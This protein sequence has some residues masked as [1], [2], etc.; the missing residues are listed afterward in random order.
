MV[1]QVDLLLTLEEFCGAEGDF[2]NERGATF[3]PMFCQ[4]LQILYD[5]DI[6][7]EE[8]C[9][10]WASEKENAEDE[11]CFCLPAAVDKGGTPLCQRQSCAPL[12][13]LPHSSLSANNM[14]SPF[15]QQDK[16]FL[17]KAQPFLTW[18][19]EAESDEESEEE[20]SE[21]E[22]DDE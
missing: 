3:A 4:V 17:K 20:E 8:A 18:L 11:V 19:K 6:I 13:S 21:E 16:A 9:E 7:S 1:L 2:A 14:F 5:M 10:A 12:I 15:F 22:E